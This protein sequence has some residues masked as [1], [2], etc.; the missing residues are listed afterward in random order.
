[1]SDSYKSGLPKTSDLLPHAE[2]APPGDQH[3][4]NNVGQ[5]DS[6]AVDSGKHGLA[7]QTAPV[8]EAAPSVGLNSASS[9]PPVKGSLR[10]RVKAFAALRK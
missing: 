10:D 9:H 7:H 1:M 4:S 5:A 3:E 2:Q 6:A 8:P